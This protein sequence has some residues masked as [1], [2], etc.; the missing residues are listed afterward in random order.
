LYMH[1]CGGVYDRGIMID[2]VKHHISNQRCLHCH[3]ALM[4]KP[5]SSAAREAHTAVFVHPEAPEN[6]CVECHTH[7]GHERE[8]KLF[9]P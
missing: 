3:D 9:K 1:Y 6:R 8:S 2:H 7:V 5:S 4:V